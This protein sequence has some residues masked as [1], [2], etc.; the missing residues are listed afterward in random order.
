[1]NQVS[2]CA[3][4]V[5]DLS[6]DFARRILAGLTCGADWRHPGFT[7]LDPALTRRNQ[8]GGCSM[9]AAETDFRTMS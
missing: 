1:M 4:T 3:V 8:S 9:K 6:L 7:A 2:P 5:T